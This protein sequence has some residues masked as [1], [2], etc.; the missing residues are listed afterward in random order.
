MNNLDPTV[1]DDHA[2][3]V[4]NDEIGPVMAKVVELTNADIGGL[5]RLAVTMVHRMLL[6]G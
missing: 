6:I 5:V 1:L 4:I 3:L 2:A